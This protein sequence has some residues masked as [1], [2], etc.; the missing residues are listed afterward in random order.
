MP[1]ELLP[2][3]EYKTSHGLDW[4]TNWPVGTVGHAEERDFMET[5]GRLREVGFGRMIQLVQFAWDRE[6]DAS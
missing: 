2:I 5:V 4:Y 3:K 6:E 1:D